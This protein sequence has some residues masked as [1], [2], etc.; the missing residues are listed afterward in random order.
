MAEAH[1]LRL[2]GDGVLVDIHV[3][4]GAA[5]DVVAGVERLGGR[6][7]VVTDMVRTWVEALA[8]IQ[9]LADVAGLDG[10]QFVYPLVDPAAAPVPAPVPVPAPR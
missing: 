2:V 6:A 3:E 7:S 5:A 4:R 9:R 10:V 1:A 8:P